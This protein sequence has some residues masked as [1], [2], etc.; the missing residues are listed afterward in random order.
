[1]TDR[2]FP[3][4]LERGTEADIERSD[5]VLQRKYDGSRIIVIKGADIEM[6]TRSWKNEISGFYPEVVEELRKLVDGIYDA[7]MTFFDANGDDSI[8][9]VLSPPGSEAR[10]GKT[11]KLMIFDVLEYDGQ[12]VRNLTFEE[13]QH[14]LV[15]LLKD[16]GFKHIEKIISITKNKTAYLEK[17]RQRGLEGAVLKRC[18]SR[19]VEGTRSKDWL[20]VKFWRSDDVIILGAT[21]G[22]GV[23]ASTFGA[24]ILGQ[25]DRS[26][27]LKYVGKTSGFTN[28]VL[29]ELSSEL[30][31]HETN[32]SSISD[33]IP[34]VKIWTSPDLVCE[35]KFMERT[36][37]GK[38]RFPDFVRLRDDKLP[39]ECILPDSSES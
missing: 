39:R 4:L 14:I 32:M 17:L 22:K 29:L 38:M 7:E 5:M 21:K 33:H 23:R 18:G 11:P 25:Y 24:L 36:D 15:T 35:M 27:K 19:Y 3:M 16:K 9:T 12:D 37:D 30:K 34:D 31:N 8:L 10:I 20:K 13:R 6:W 2:I 1:M 26:G 28:D